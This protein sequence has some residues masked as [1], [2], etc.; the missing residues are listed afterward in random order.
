VKDNPA[1]PKA[2]AHIKASDDLQAV[3][4]LRAGYERMTEQLSHAIVGQQ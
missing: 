2:E 3:K 4:D 1:A